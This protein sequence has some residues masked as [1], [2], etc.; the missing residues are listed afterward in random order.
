M[1]VEERDAHTGYLTTGHEWNGIT[2]LNRPVPKIIWL[3][4][5][6]TFLFALV[7][8][9]LMPAWPLGATYTR[10]L[11]GVDQRARLAD[12]MASAA[13]ARADWMA[14]IESKPVEAIRADPD[15]MRLARESGRT[16]FADNCG[17]CHGVTGAGGPGYP[18]LVDTAWLWGGDAQSVAETIRVGINTGHPE[19]RLSQMLAFGR[20]GILERQALSDVVSYVRSLSQA[21]LAPAEQAGVAAGATIFADNCAACHGEDGRGSQDVGAPDLTDGFWIYGGDRRSILISVDRGRQGEMPS[22]E[23]RLS[24]VQ[25]KLLTLYVLDLG[26]PQ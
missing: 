2:E 26:A 15:L 18:S 19:S 12:D 11:L 8:W 3:F 6:S 22:W 9:V 25:R 23:T 20:D 10:G 4:L 24:P 7:W 21:P 16:L 14:E 5:L 1:A 17:V 13:A